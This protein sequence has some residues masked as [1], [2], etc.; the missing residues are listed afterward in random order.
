MLVATLN[1]TQ[2]HANSLFI[3][4]LKISILQKRGALVD[5]LLI[6][7]SGWII[8]YDRKQVS[9]NLLDIDELMAPKVMFRI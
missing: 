1:Q 2:Q 8:L 5:K 4:V 3:S 7:R 9:N 6:R